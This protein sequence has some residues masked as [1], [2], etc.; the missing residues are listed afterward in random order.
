[1][2]C[3]PIGVVRSPVTEAVDKG[4]GRIV[5]RVELEPEYAAGLQGLA[6]FSH[7]LIL[8]LMHEATFDASRHLRRRPRDLA[9]MPEIGI[10]AQRARHRPNPIG[11]TAVEL[12]NIEDN[13]IEVRGL[14]AVDGTPVLDMKPYMAIYDR[15]EAPQEPEWVARLMAEYF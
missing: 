6:E 15:I 14:D 7:V 9:D 10:F 2:E 1:M 8:F 5:A 11:V 13:V 12:L 3:S 4:W